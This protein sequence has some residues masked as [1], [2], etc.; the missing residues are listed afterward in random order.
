MSRGAFVLIGAGSTVFTPGL[1]T[2]LA[3]SRAF[4][5]LSG[6]RERAIQALVLDPLVPDRATA[7]AIL[8][9]AVQADSDRLGRF[10]ETRESTTFTSTTTGEPR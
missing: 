4:A 2:D 7:L 1:L 3:G 10:G 8:D 5:A 9:A 6:S